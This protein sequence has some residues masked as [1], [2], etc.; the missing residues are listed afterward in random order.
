MGSS[1]SAD[2]RERCLREVGIAIVIEGL[3][4]FHHADAISRGKLIALNGFAIGR[5]TLWLAT[6]RASV[7]VLVMCWSI[8][9]RHG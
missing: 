1:N 3:C 7:I 4:V 9:V 6:V 5:T 2:G 8:I